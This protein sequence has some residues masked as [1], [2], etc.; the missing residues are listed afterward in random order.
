M[1]LSSGFGSAQGVLVHVEAQC[2]LQVHR[3][4]EI[5]SKNGGSGNTSEKSF[6]EIYRA[7]GQNA[8]LDEGVL[9][10]RREA[11]VGSVLYFLEDSGYVSVLQ[12]WAGLEHS[13]PKLGVVTIFILLAGF[14]LFVLGVGTREREVPAT[15]SQHLSAG[16]NP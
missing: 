6:G 16:S 12:Q 2:Q 5:S 3:S 13:Y 9:Q 7:E 15:S 4:G 8:P 11:V 10:P 14:L 1:P